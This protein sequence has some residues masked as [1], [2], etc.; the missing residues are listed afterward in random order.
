M[1][2]SVPYQIRIWFLVGSVSNNQKRAEEDA[3]FGR[4]LISEVFETVE[5]MDKQIINFK[6]SISNNDEDVKYRKMMLEDTQARFKPSSVSLNGQNRLR[7]VL[8][9]KWRN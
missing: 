5:K 7:S 1:D 3:E 8:T 9:S 6:K 2:R 4:H